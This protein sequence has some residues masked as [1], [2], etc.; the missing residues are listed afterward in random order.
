MER[1]RFL[2]WNQQRCSL[3]S[4]RFNYCKY[5]ILK[6]IAIQIMVY[7]HVIRFLSSWEIPSTGY[8][9][10]DPSVIDRW[11]YGTET[12]LK[13]Y[14]EAIELIVKKMISESR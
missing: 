10:I 7:F 11:K 3:S 9:V 14:Y 4:H 5:H 1:C 2:Y 13:F 12:R 6:G 8:I